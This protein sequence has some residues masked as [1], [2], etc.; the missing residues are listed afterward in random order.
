MWLLVVKFAV[1]TTV[2]LSVLPERP[3]VFATQIDCERARVRIEADLPSSRD[4]LACERADVVHN[5]AVEEDF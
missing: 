3:V 5:R 4:P 2:T 1:A